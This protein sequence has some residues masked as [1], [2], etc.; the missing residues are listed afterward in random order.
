MPPTQ[1]TPFVLAAEPGGDKLR[2]W[3]EAIHRTFGAMDMSIQDDSR[4]SGA[5]RCTPFRA[6]ELTEVRSSNEFA[7][8]TRRH[9]AGDTQE[10]VALLLVKQGKVQIDQYGRRNMTGAGMFTLLDLNEPYDYSHNR[11]AHV[12]GIK[13]TA[14]FLA[15]QV[16]D[17]RSHVGRPRA[18]SN[19]IGRMAADFLEAFAREIERIPEAAGEALERQFLELTALLLNLPETDTALPEMSPAEAIYWR[20]LAHIDRHLGDP[21]LGP[22]QVAQAMPVSVRY[23]QAIFRSFGTSV[24]ETIQSRRLALCHER[25]AA[26]PS[27]RVSE[28]AYRAGF[29]SHA[30]FTTAFKAKY[31]FP[32]RDLRSNPS[33]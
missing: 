27:L 25:L 11:P 23:I 15:Q 12:V 30:H 9:L 29:K 8:R 6:L 18:A 17:F 5:I 26:D 24:T 19:G 7:R 4:F 13:L 2:R 28:V 1:K 10:M 16:R 3:Q 20:A 22:A 33:S 32:P 14:R 31:G 21:D